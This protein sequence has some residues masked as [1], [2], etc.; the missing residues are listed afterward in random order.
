MKNFDAAENIFVGQK[1][2]DLNVVA[3]TWMRAPGESVGVF[4]LE[5]ALDE[6]AYKLNVD[7]IELRR[8][9]E[10]GKGSDQ[11]NTV[12]EPAPDRGVRARR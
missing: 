7:P 8:R 10:P 5:S 4:V 12:L 1:V 6:P 11:G 9:N 3:N 2:V